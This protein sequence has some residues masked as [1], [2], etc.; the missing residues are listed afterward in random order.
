MLNIGKIQAVPDV[1]GYGDVIGVLSSD[2]MD[3]FSL[4]DTARLYVTL[5]ERQGSFDAQCMW[6]RV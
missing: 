1:T 6:F 2:G 4:V 5:V 3:K